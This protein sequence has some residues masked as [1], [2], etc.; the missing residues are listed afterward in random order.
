[1]KDQKYWNNLIAKSASR[2]FLLASLAR[3][4]MHGYRLAKVIAQG[5]DNCCTP[6]DAMIY[7]TI[8]EMTEA[9]LISCREEKQGGRIRKVCELT[10][11]GRKAFRTAA[12]AWGRVLPSLTTAVE[13][14]LNPS[15]QGDQDEQADRRIDPECCE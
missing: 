1:M 5:C 4:P 2:F 15:G 11:T 10:E 8:K 14:G 7:P 12:E 9:G 3:S 13:L 6:T